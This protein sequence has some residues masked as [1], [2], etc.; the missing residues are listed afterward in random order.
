MK[1][2]NTIFDDTIPEWQ[3]IGTQAFFAGLAGFVMSIAVYLGV[4]YLV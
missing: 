2:F 1:Y 3:E 4:F